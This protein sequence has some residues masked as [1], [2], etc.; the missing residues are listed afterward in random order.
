M[1]QS[2]STNTEVTGA[3]VLTPAKSRVD[4]HDLLDAPAAGA[5]MPP[6][7]HL[8]DGTANHRKAEASVPARFARA[9]DTF[10]SESPVAPGLGA[11]RSVIDGDQ[12]KRCCGAMS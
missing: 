8:F 3:A 11:L 7:D 2:A 9:R 10:R 12:R 6:P 5:E 1:W 4:L